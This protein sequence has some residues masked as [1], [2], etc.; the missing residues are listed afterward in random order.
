MYLHI[1]FS[2]EKHENRFNV[3]IDSLEVELAS[4]KRILEHEKQYTK[5]FEI[6]TM[7]KCGTKVTVK[8]EAIAQ[9]EKEYGASLC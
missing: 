4:G 1:Y 3:S 8:Q 2:G 7:S 9:T 6:T 5:Y